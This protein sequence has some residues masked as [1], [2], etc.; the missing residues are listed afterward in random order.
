MPSLRETQVALRGAILDEDE[1]AMRGGMPLAGLAVY[2]NAYRARLAGALRVNYPVLAQ[3]LGDEGFRS[4]ADAYA[5]SHPSRSPSIRWHGADLARF[6]APGPRADLARMEWALGAAFDAADAAPLDAAFLRTVP[7][8][9]WQAL[10]VALHPSV[11]VLRLS[12]AIEPQ[13]EAIRA[14]HEAPAAQPDPHGL[15]VWRRGLDARWRI[16]SLEESAALLALGRQANLEAACESLDE[17]QAESLGEW[18]ASWTVD[19]L[20]V[21]A[22]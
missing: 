22:R 6:L 2:R 13:W 4:I 3:L 1:P 15:I 19:G 14:G 21:A 7:V 20:L 16:A 9:E 10:R 18:F 5:R 11:A 8:Y 12:F 17:E